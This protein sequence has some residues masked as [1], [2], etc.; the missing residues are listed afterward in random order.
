MFKLGNK[1]VIT[2]NR[3][4]PFHHSESYSVGERGTVIQA[5]E[6]SSVV[7]LQL[8]GQYS[9]V[10]STLPLLRRPVASRI[11]D[12]S[13]LHL[14]EAPEEV[15]PEAAQKAVLD[16][17]AH[18]RTLGSMAMLSLEAALH[19]ATAEHWHHVKEEKEHLL[20]PDEPVDGPV[21]VP[22]VVPG[23]EDASA[24]IRDL[25][26][27]ADG[28][29]IRDL[30]PRADATVPEAADDCPIELERR[31]SEELGQLQLLRQRSKDRQLP[32]R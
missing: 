28:A 12:A 3:Y 9:I 6:N 25:P 17:D 16:K 11:V 10:E 1:V 23:E 2:N 7:T 15:L 4:N 29:T 26:P 31:L 22:I 27:R 13:V 20:H 5:P 14:A 21:V 30:P 32:E 8:E 18:T 19:T 24:T